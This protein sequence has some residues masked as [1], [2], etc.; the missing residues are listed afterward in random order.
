V[1]TRPGRV[2]ALARD[3]QTLAGAAAAFLAQPDLAA[4]TRR[5]YQQ[6]LGG[7]NARSAATSHWPP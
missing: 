7:S 4:S 1:G 2:V 6:T 5:S 3:G